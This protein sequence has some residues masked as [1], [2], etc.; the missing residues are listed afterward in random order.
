MI[1]SLLALLRQLGAYPDHYLQMK[2]MVNVNVLLITNA[3][4]ISVSS[5]LTSRLGTLNLM[6]SASS[7]RFGIQLAKNVFGPLLQVF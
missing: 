7:C 2:V 1:L 4:V 3:R 6:G 5:G